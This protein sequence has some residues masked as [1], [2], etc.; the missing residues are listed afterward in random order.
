MFK[1]KYY[2]DTK[3]LSYRKIKVSKGVQLRNILTFL[4]ASSFF[5]IV[6]LLTL[7]KS[8][9]INTPTASTLWT[10]LFYVNHIFIFYLI[11]PLN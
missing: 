6:V 8:P 4:I 7:L 2:Y 10:I 11:L 3:T 1:T 9:L 5:G